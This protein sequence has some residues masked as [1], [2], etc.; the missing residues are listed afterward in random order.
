MMDVLNDK[1]NVDRNFHSFQNTNNGKRTVDEQFQI[2]VP[3][4]YQIIQVLGKGS[5]GIVISAR[6]LKNTKKFDLAIK[7][8]NNILYKEILLKRAIR[9]IKFLTFFSGHRNIVGIYDL[10]L[11]EEKPFDGLYC[12]Q[13][14]ID[15][16]LAKVIH[17]SIQLT[18]FHIK[19]FMYQ[20]FCGLKYIH[21]ADVI[22]RDLKPG[23]ILVTISG[24][25]KICD[26]GLARGINQQFMTKA[27]GAGPNKT[28]S[29][30]NIT[31]YVATRWYR[32]PELILSHKLYSKAIDVWATGCIL[33][34]FY[35][36]KPIFM[37]KDSLHQVYEMMKVLGSAPNSLLIKFGS[38]RS[39]QLL[40]NKKKIAPI[41][42]IK[43]FPFMDQYAIEL[44]DNILT[45]DPEQRLTVEEILE[46]PFFSDVRTP[47]DE[48]IHPHG[49]FNFT[50]EAQL[51]SM[52]KL[53]NYLSNEVQL[54]H[55]SRKA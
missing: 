12:Y 54:F 13:E 19:Y 48:P 5:Y 22:H 17:S 34:E 20:I 24:C 38:S 18:E 43:S 9:E 45:W 3:A 44:L 1:I 35:K 55:I 40:N 30:N 2:S 8:L 46:N 11:L 21:S 49:P 15:Y 10:E 28:N 25:L 50:Y 23:N 51:D 53:R 32:A 26:F 29:N 39:W 33:A 4:R 52:A 36:R 16:D 37:G 27:D 41:P 42:W 7:K 31:N 47:D 6:D 14:L